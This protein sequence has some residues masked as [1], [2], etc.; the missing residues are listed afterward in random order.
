M[1]KNVPENPDNEKV[2]AEVKKYVERYY[3]PEHLWVQP[4]DDGKDINMDFTLGTQRGMA[5]AFCAIGELLGMD[6][7]TGLDSKKK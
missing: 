2:L 7:P 6:L 3:F 4:R 1:L 5:I